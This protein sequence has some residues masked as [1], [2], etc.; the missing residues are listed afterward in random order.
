MPGTFR[1]TIEE[2]FGN[3]LT[4]LLQV[5][6][7]IL[8]AAALYIGSREFM[9]AA[10]RWHWA[11]GLAVALVYAFLVY[12]FLRLL[13]RSVA[14]RESPL[15]SAAFFLA[16]ALTAISVCAWL[17]FALHTHLGAPYRCAQPLTI[18]KFCDL[19]GWTF[20]EMIPVVDVWKTLHITNPVESLSPLAAAPELL[21][22]LLVV[23]PLLAAFKQWLDQRKKPA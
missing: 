21:F 6:V 20:I 11:L 16:A 3:I 23:V 18:E 7:A 10:G 2:K 9:G 12:V 1:S 13:H 22:R 14:E 15:L 8:V 5:F 19:Y 4:W 17:S